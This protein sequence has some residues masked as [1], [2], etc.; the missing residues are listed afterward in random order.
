[1][2]FCL[3]DRFRN[4]D[5]RWLS[6]F[7]VLRMGRQLMLESPP[8]LNILILQGSDFEDLTFQ[9]R[10]QAFVRCPAS[11]STTPSSIKIEEMG[12]TMLAGEKLLVGC[13]EL[14]LASDLLPADRV[15]SVTSIPTAIATG[16]VLIG[17]P[18]DITGWSFAGKVK[19]TAGETLVTFSCAI[20]SAVNGTFKPIISKVITAAIG[21]N[22]TWQDYQ[23]IDIQDIG[24]PIDL[25]KY[26]PDAVKRL[27]RISNTAYRWD[28]ESTDTGGKTKRRVEGLAIV[29]G[30]V[31]N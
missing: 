24:K 5:C 23:G 20:V 1:V 18:I 16:Q 8:V 27:K 9:L 19:T 22:C 31:T 30:E 6:V 26:A 14:V 7:S 3:C 12:V 13:D 17:K 2:G 10:S 25:E 15:A 28:V 29:S 4:H 11:V 21:Q